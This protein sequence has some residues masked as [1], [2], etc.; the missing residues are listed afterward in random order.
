MAGTRSLLTMTEHPCAVHVN[1]MVIKNSD[2]TRISCLDNH[3]IRDFA[4]S[5]GVNV[6]NKSRDVIE[7]SLD[8]Q[9]PSCNNDEYCQLKQAGA[10]ELL[11][12]YKVIK[13]PEINDWLYN[14]DIDRAM[15]PYMKKYRDFIFLGAFPIDF[16]AS[17]ENMNPH[18]YKICTP[19]RTLDINKF[20]QQGIS[21]IGAVFNTQPHNLG[22]EHWVCT[23]I[24]VLQNHMYYYN[25]TGKK[26][27]PEIVT[28]KNKV[29]MQGQ[30][31][32]HPIRFEQNRVKN[33]QSTSECGVYCLWFINGMLENNSFDTLVKNAPDDH[34]M[35]D[36]ARRAFFLHD[37]QRVR[38]RGGRLE[39]VSDNKLRY[40]LRG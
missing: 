16:A 15:H 8:A 22:G 20:L 35:K 31:T 26:A 38:F 36:I 9:F 2:T 7:Q 28:L 17:K 6:T 29:V 4:E 40:R 34:W 23:Y 19:I 14:V 10:N 1:P 37:G 24:D 5:Q 25:S 3:K 12:N 27:P 21:K 30:L 13:E 33:Q 18:W 32:N 11:S 39:P